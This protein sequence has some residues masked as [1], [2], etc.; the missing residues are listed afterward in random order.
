MAASRQRSTMGF[1]L[2]TTDHNN[3]WTTGTRHRRQ[4]TRFGRMPCPSARATSVALGFSGHKAQAGTAQRQIWNA[5]RLVC[6]RC[7]PHS[8]N[9]R[10][11]SA[12]RAFARPIPS[13]PRQVQRH[14]VLWC[15]TVVCCDGQRPAAVAGG[16][17]RPGAAAPACA[18]ASRPGAN[19][20]CRCQ[21][22]A[23]VRQWP[24]AGAG[25]P[26]VGAVTL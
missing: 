7:K 6:G 15:A 14:G 25:L 8:R 9:C 21:P 23:A 3:G 12:Q 22:P 2:A 16:L 18:G 4:N 10:P 24:R 5:A 13:Q 19:R 26:P 17:R 1:V 11:H 20:R